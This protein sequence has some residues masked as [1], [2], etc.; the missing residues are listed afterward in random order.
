MSQDAVVASVDDGKLGV[1]Q[2]R[3]A[4]RPCQA[5]RA[6]DQTCDCPSEGI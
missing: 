1:A 4:N 6:A 2:G 5:E 3:F